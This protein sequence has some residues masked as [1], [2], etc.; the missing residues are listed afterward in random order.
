MNNTATSREKILVNVFSSHIGGGRSVALNFLKTMNFGSTPVDI[1]VLCRP[2]DDFLAVCDTNGYKSIVPPKIL[3]N[4]IGTLILYCAV[5]PVLLSLMRFRSVINFA[6]IP[7][8]FLGKQ[9]FYFDWPYAIYKDQFIWGRLSKKEYIASKVKLHIFRALSVFVDIWL[10]QTNVV[11]KRLIATGVR[12]EIVFT[13]NSVS[14]EDNNGEDTSEFSNSLPTGPVYGL[15][16]TAYYAHK[17]IE[18]LIDTA[19][20]LKNRNFPVKFVLTLN[21]ADPRVQKIMLQINERGLEDYFV[22]LGHVEKRLIPS[23]YK[24]VNFFILPTLLETFTGT[25]IEAAHYRCPI[26]TSDLDFSRDVCGEYAAYFDP[27][28]AT[29]VAD[30]VERIVSDTSYRAWLIDKAFQHHLTAPSWES[31]SKTIVEVS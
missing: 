14:V 2:D 18:I 20:I 8:I 11:K 1:L 9:V 31:V 6:D 23:L 4:K 28:S 29:S 13:P 19:G 7:I 27:L 26:V 21:N 10:V 12:G 17:N 15:C 16:L 25:Y 3:R 22:N 5:L 30:A 24:A